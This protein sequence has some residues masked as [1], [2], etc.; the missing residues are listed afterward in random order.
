MLQNNG[1][2]VVVNVGG[3]NTLRVTS[4]GNVNANYFMFVPVTTITVTAAQSGGNAVIS[5]P[6]TAGSSYRVYYSSSLI[7]GTW[8][9][10][11]QVGGNGAVKSVSDSTAGGTMRFY[12]VTSP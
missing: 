12:K 7:G 4:G 2:P 3:T 1:V 5:F 6:T 10:L 8:T 9:Q 11:A